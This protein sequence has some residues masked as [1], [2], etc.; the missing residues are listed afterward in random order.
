MRAFAVCVRGCEHVPASVGESLASLAG[1]QQG[2]LLLLTDS[3][4][5][6]GL[7]I[8]VCLFAA[9]PA[10]LLLPASRP[11]RNVK[12]DS[13]RLMASAC[14]GHAPMLSCGGNGLGLGCR[15]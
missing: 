2:A 11:N 9:L 14:Q 7:C 3:T 8:S 12:Q 10:V 5:A 4:R 15:V 1:R 13:R 6:V